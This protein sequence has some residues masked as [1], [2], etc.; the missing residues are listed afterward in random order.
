[1][2]SDLDR[3]LPPSDSQAPSESPILPI[4]EPSTNLNINLDIG[5]AATSSIK[6]NG[7]HWRRLPL[8]VLYF[9]W[10]SGLIYVISMLIL[11]GI[12]KSVLSSAATRARPAAACKP[13]GSFTLYV[14]PG[15]GMAFW[16]KTGFFQ[17]TMGMGNLTFT[18]AK[19]VDVAWDL[20]VG[21]GGQAAM[22][23][24]ACRVFVNYVAVYLERNHVSYNVFWDIFLHQEP[25]VVG[26]YRLMRD[27]SFY[28]AFRHRLIAAFVC[29]TLVLIIAF[30]TVASAMSGYAPTTAAF[31]TVSTGSSTVDDFISFRQFEIV[32]YIIHDG[33][34][35]GMTDDL[36]VPYVDRQG[37]PATYDPVMIYEDREA[38]KDQPYRHILD[39]CNAPTTE[40]FGG[41]CSP[42]LCKLQLT[43]S[44]Y[45]EQYGFYGLNNTESKWG[46]STILQAPALNITAFY[47]MPS[48]FRNLWG[49][50]WAHPNTSLRPFQ[51]PENIRYSFNNKLYNLTYMQANG[52]CQPDSDIYQ[53][54]F[55]YIQLFIVAVIMLI[56]SIG[57]AILWLQ[58]NINLPL[59]NFPG[60]IPKGWRRLLHLACEM[61]REFEG[62]KIQLKDPTDKQL[63]AVIDKHL[64]GGKV[65][66][67]SPTALTKPHLSLGRFYTQNMRMALWW[68]VVFGMHVAAMC[69]AFLDHHG[70]EFIPG[71]H[72]DR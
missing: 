34:R 53:W 33:G 72:Y 25:S 10:I 56:W 8:W 3:P 24:L 61:N 60:G 20:V 51:N 23:F 42:E 30:P 16:D 28:R 45:V 58:A 26:T 41:S 19:I 22:A 2:E 4:T 70:L 40:S 18:Q 29:F 38:F 66:F 65:S 5:N 11:W 13:D 37:K 12:N 27:S 17:I 63:A 52:R 44:K 50:D 36:V 64:Q 57:M 6:S 62:E 69:L 49:H 46:N 43:T 68:T 67:K 35:I 9:A 31:I 1:M 47:L 59:A 54:G 15:Q 55:S 39:S 21:R 7:V 48:L 71:K 32:A 14:W